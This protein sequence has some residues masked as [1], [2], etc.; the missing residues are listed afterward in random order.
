MGR[1]GGGRGGGGEGGEGEGFGLQ[2]LSAEGLLRLLQKKSVVWFRLQGSFGF[3]CNMCEKCVVSS[4]NCASTSFP[5]QT[6]HTVFTK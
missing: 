3:V 6:K 2:E 5:R 4:R 1:G